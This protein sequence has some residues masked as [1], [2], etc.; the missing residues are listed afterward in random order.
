MIGRCA[1]PRIEEILR[2]VQLYKHI[3]I[4]TDGSQ[5]AGRAVRH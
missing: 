5:L 3:L 1:A 4:P 2:E